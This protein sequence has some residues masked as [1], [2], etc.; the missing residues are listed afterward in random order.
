MILADR[1]SKISQSY[2]ATNYNKPYTTRIA[3][4]LLQRVPYDRGTS[5][6]FAEEKKKKE[7]RFMK[8]RGRFDQRSNG[9]SETSFLL[10]CFGT[11]Y[12]LTCL[13]EYSTYLYN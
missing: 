1:R 6:F 4:F 5:I 3:I 12:I 13:V 10:L 11:W 7:K 8:R 9:Q 2:N